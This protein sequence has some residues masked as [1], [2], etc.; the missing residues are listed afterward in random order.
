MAYKS[1]ENVVDFKY[2]VTSLTVKTGCM[3]KFGA[4]C[5][6]AFGLAAFVFLL[7]LS[8]MIK[9]QNCKVAYSIVYGCEVLYCTLRE[10]IGGREEGVEEDT[11]WFRYDRD[12]LRL[13]YTQIVPV[14]FE[15][16]CI[17]T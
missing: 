7:F 16:P 1:T 5:M 3:K 2:V 14:I 9:K 11:G 6:L 8:V 4:E 13:V 10:Y 17:W 12:K 15:P